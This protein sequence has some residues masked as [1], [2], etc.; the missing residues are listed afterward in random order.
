M[1]RAKTQSTPSSENGEIFFLCALGALAGENF[2]EWFCQT[3]QTIESKNASTRLSMDGKSPK[4]SISPPFV[5]RP[6]KDERRVL[7]QQ[8][9]SLGR[10]YG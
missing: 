5:L 4:I 6:S 9:Q 3:F 7:L 2:L 10:N 8:K 1:T